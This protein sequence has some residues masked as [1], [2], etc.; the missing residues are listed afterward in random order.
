MA[1][2]HQDAALNRL[3]GEDVTRLNK[4]CWLGISGNRRLHCACA[5][6]SRDAGRDT[7]GRLNRSREG[8]RFLVAVAQGHG[9]QFETLA[10]FAAQGQA[11]QAASKARHEVDRVRRD[12][13]GC[14]QQIALVFAV[15]F[16]DQNDHASGAQVGHNIF[17]G[18][19]GNRREGAHAGIFQEARW[20]EGAASGWSMRST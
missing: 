10:V 11:N 18:G 17:N 16:I 14:Q 8:G 2:A 15:F 4:I 9:R 5:V 19:N 12:V 13:V 7:L 3:Q 6:G 20:E 1:S